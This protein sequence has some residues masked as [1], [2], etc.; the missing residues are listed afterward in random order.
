M[1]CRS[2]ILAAPWRRLALPLR[3]SSTYVVRQIALSVTVD[4]KMLNA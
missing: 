4:H 1:G 3:P 2:A